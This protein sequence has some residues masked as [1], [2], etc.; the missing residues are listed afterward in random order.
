MSVTH[1]DHAASNHQ[2]ISAKKVAPPDVLPTP[3][4]P[5][6][7]RSSPKIQDR[8]RDRLAVV[9]VRQSSPHQVLE[10]RES[11]ERQYGLAMLAQQFGWPADRVLV[12]DEDQGSAASRPRIVAD[13]SV[14]RTKWRW[15]MSAWFWDWS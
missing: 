10:N 9:Y 2:A 8:H 5:P 12:I 13:S 3:S 14:C 15:I 7:L 6:T 1:L 11:R 4:V